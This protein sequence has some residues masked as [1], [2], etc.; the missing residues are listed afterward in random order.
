[1]I[2]YWGRVVELH[3]ES[4]I[5]KVLYWHQG[6]KLWSWFCR[7]WW[8]CGKFWINAITIEVVLWSRTLQKS[9][10]WDR[11]HGHILLF[12]TL[13][14]TYFLHCQIRGF[15]KSKLLYGDLCYTSLKERVWDGLVLLNLDT[16]LDH[17]V[18]CGY[19]IFFIN[20]LLD[21]ETTVMEGR[22]KVKKV[23]LLAKLE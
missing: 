18:W 23:Q 7:I 10:C 1:M 11:N 20:W 21:F 8:Y 22:D 12:K 13:I 15:P 14:D 6:F 19:W 17:N 3:K 16:K 4:W 2:S 5:A 9:R